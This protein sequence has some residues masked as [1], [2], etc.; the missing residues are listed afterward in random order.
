MS[1]RTRRDESFLG[2]GWA[3]PPSFSAGGGDVAM[4]SGPE[5]IEQS[6]RILLRTSP[7]ERVMNEAFGCDLQRLLFEELDQRLLNTAHRLISTAIIEHE[8]RIR[9]DHIDVTR[10]RTEAGAIIVS[11]HYTVRGTNSRFNMVFPFYLTE[12]TRPGA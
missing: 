3:F 4:V 10:S 5:D 8:P 12:A 11:L 6:L 9:L 2:R 1:D 7:G